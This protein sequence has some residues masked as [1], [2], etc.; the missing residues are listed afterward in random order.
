[1]GRRLRQSPTGSFVSTCHMAEA[2]SLVIRSLCYLT[3]NAS[4]K[5]KQKEQQQTPNNY[6]FLIPKNAVI[7]LILLNLTF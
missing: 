3:W 5:Q 7:I 1:M 6:F 4:Q 2:L